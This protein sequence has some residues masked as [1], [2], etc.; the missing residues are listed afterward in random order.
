[1]LVSCDKKNSLSHFEMAKRQRNDK[2]DWKFKNCLSLLDC[3][4]KNC[5]NELERGGEPNGLIIL[6]IFYH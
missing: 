1:M 4:L 3:K 6:N 2:Q 5:Y